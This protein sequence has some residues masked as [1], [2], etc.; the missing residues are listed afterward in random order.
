MQFTAK[1]DDN[2]MLEYF[3]SVDDFVQKVTKERTLSADTSNNH[4]DWATALKGNPNYS[5]HF[6]TGGVRFADAMSD[7]ECGVCSDANTRDWYDKARQEAAKVLLGKTGSRTKTYAK[8]KR[9]SVAAGGGSP[10]IDR[11]LSGTEYHWRRKQNQAFHPL[12]TLGVGISAA[13]STD[14]KKF[15]ECWGRATALAEQLQN[16]GFPVRIEAV[17]GQSGDGG[18]F[19]TGS[20]TRHVGQ[21]ICVKPADRRV[22]PQALMSLGHPVFYRVLC[23]ESW[24]QPMPRGLAQFKMDSGRGL[25]TPAKRSAA[26]EK[27]HGDRYDLMLTPVEDMQDLTEAYLSIVNKGLVRS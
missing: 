7:I 23:F 15:A 25:C 11:Y 18:Q 21:G 3:D 17:V 10:M 19:C 24:C 22:D 13:C 4:G 2:I 5:D 27:I 26:Y 6:H 8:R 12:V 16:D 20:G 9:N 14:G 1:H